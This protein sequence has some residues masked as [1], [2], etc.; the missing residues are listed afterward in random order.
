MSKELLEFQWEL[1]TPGY[2]W[3]EVRRLSNVVMEIVDSEPADCTVLIPESI[4]LPQTRRYA[5]LRE[6]TGLFRIL[7]DVELS[8]A[9]VLAFA[10]RYGSLGTT[11]VSVHDPSRCECDTFPG[12]TWEAW[13]DAIATLRFAVRLWELARANDQ[14]GLEKHVHWEDDD[15]VHCYTQRQWATVPTGH[16]LPLGE[17]RWSTRRSYDETLLNIRPG[18]LIMPARYC[19]QF[20][21]NHYLSNTIARLLW[22]RDHNR[23]EVCFVPLNL[24]AAVWLQ[25]AQ[26]VGGDKG[27]RSCEQCGRWFELSTQ[28]GRADKVFCRNACRS[29]ASR[30]RQLQAQQMFGD[31]KSVADIAQFLQSSEDVVR[32]WITPR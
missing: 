7:A 12:E 18:D 25:F 9:G 1:P 10:N 15:L 14:A 4:D 6:E 29:R 11:R 22:N 31:G 30:R 3:V 24:L 20:A 28:A 8:P 2:R 17:C 26:A 21:M 19:V 13:V 32:R 27:Y 16:P 5:P 23:Q